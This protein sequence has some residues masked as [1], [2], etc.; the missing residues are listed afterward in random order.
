[1]MQ[2]QAENFAVMAL[3]TLPTRVADP[4]AHRQHFFRQLRAR[5]SAASYCV[6]SVHSWIINNLRSKVK[7][8]DFFQSLVMWRA[9]RDPRTPIPPER[10]RET[11]INTGDFLFSV[12]VVIIL[13]YS[14]P[15]ARFLASLA[16]PLHA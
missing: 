1:M 3:F 5:F 9:R 12:R 15:A 2:E 11:S 14:R 16:P 6:S 7:S 10:T 4:G 13:V 8:G